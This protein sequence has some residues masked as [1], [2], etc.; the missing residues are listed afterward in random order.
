M[1]RDAERR[2]ADAGRVGI[3]KRHGPRHV[4]RPSVIV[5]SHEA[6][7]S[8]DRLPKRDGRTAEISSTPEWQARVAPEENRSGDQRA[9]EPA[10]EITGAR[11]HGPRDN[12]RRRGDVLW[13]IPHDHER[14]GADDRAGNRPE[15]KRGERVDVQT[16]P[17]SLS[18]Q[19]PEGCQVRRCQ[20][21]AERVERKKG[22]GDQSRVHWEPSERAGP[23]GTSP[24]R[25][26]F[27]SLLFQH[28]N[29]RDSDRIGLH[30]AREV[31]AIRETRSG[32]PLLSPSLT[33]E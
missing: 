29:V 25:A 16:L 15:P 9:Y 31:L 18:R 10:V 11:E 12:A 21:Q 5:A 2:T 13:Q 28:L 19:P 7:Y 3:G 6:S 23:M 32:R 14:L 17:T 26:L 30:V 1:Q 8:A 33:T 24:A 27:V 4:R 20:Q 22:G